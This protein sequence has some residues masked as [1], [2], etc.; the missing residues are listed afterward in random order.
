LNAQTGWR[1]I[2]QSFVEYEAL[3]IFENPDFEKRTGGR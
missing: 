1:L 2:G 3:A